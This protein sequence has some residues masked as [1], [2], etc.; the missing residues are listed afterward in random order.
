[1]LPVIW[2]PELLERLKGAPLGKR[3]ENREE[4]TKY[5]HVDGWGIYPQ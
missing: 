5:V 4:K 1:M 3:Y 2:T